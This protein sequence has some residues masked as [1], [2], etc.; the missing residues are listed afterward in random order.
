M[1]GAQ[2]SSR[3]R[4][5]HVLR[6]VPLGQLC[7]SLVAC[8]A[9]SALGMVLAGALGD[10]ICF[11]SSACRHS[12]SRRFSTE[13][14]WNWPSGRF[15][16]SWPHARR[17]SSAAPTQGD[18]ESQPNCE[19]PSMNEAVRAQV[20]SRGHKEIGTLKAVI[21]LSLSPIANVWTGMPLD[22]EQ[23]RPREDRA[24]HRP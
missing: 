19:K 4:E 8:H 14:C 5:T 12:T 22:W 10:T 1:I 11:C 17:V 6:L 21:V 24:S 16:I 13:H 7:A 2:A 18:S 15:A 20:S 3:V 9:T 23:H